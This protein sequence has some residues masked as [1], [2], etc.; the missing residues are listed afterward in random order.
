MIIAFK[1]PQLL[2]L[3]KMLKRNLRKLKKRKKL[4]WLV[5]EIKINNQ[6]N[7]SLHLKSQRVNSVQR[8]RKLMQEMMPKMLKLTKCSR[9]TSKAWRR[10]TGASSFR[11]NSS[12]TSRR[13]SSHPISGI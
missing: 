10:C 6:E 7:V 3:P 13:S 12:T 9:E 4:R 8:Q 11:S 1:K 2:S 5:L